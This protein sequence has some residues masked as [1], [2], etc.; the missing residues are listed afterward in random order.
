MGVLRHGPIIE[1]RLEDLRV[2]P[3]LV[4]Y[5][6]ACARFAWDTE[7]DTLDG[8]PNGNLNIAHEAVDRHAQGTR[9]RH[10]ALICVRRNG[11]LHEISY[12][13]LARQSSRAANA[14][15]A[16]GL[17]RRRRGRRHRQTRSG[18]LEIIKAFLAPPHPLPSR[19]PRFP[20]PRALRAPSA[21]TRLQTSG[22]GCGSPR[23]R[24]DSPRRIPG[25][26]GP[27]RDR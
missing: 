22:S 18:R 25:G 4:H 9:A 7:R 17:R 6:A 5:D 3:H 21:H 19:S 8:L 14:F 20:R 16:L 24:A 13:T 23:P 26:E 1:K 12:T 11:S 27:P 2:T 15:L 10:V